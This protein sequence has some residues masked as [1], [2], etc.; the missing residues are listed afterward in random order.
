[1]VNIL[2]EHIEGVLRQVNRLTGCYLH[3]YG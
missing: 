1:M 3:L 2:G